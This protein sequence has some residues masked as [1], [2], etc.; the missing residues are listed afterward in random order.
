M[1]DTI[2]RTLGEA[3]QSGIRGSKTFKDRLK[4]SAAGIESFTVRTRVGNDV[5][6]I[7]LTPQIQFDPLLCVR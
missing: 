1:T 3:Q 2:N 6:A 4:L 5:L 7:N